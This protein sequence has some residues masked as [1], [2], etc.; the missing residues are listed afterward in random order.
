[1]TNKIGE[2]RGGVTQFDFLIE[3]IRSVLG[4]YVRLELLE[5]VV[6]FLTGRKDEARRLLR[7]SQAKWQQLQVWIS[8][9]ITATRLKACLTRWRAGAWEGHKGGGNA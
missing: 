5:G 8:V 1:M 4:R 6:A 3:M 2:S 9:K 7:E